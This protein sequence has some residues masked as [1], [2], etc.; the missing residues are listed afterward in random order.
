M[1]IRIHQQLPFLF[2]D[3]L[4]RFWTISKEYGKQHAPDQWKCTV[5]VKH[6]FPTEIVHDPTGRQDR[7]DRA[8]GRTTINNG[9]PHTFFLVD[10]PFADQYVDY[11]QI[12]CTNETR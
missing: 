7:Y 8:Q 10:D 5:Y 2:G 9:N 3:V 1:S 11:W 4:L 6:H 12:G